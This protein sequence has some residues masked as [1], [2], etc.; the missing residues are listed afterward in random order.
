M[1]YETIEEWESALEVL[2]F[3]IKEVPRE[4][5]FLAGC[6]FFGRMCILAISSIRWFEK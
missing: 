6:A 5:H 1:I 4:A 2:G 3:S